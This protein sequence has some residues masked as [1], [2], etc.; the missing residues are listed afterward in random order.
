VRTA[1][2]TAYADL[3]LSAGTELVLPSYLEE[4]AVYALDTD[5][6]IDATT[7]RRGTL[8]VLVP[9]RAS[10]I[11]AAASGRVVLIGGAPVDG[12]RYIWWNFVSSRNERISQA[13]DD[14][15][16]QRFRRVPGETE[17]TPLPERHPNP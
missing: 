8:A 6:L 17:F 4:L 13:A 2:E 5:L 1:S 10:H 15:E 11:R 14:W 3:R 16:Q 12:R 7:V 9:H